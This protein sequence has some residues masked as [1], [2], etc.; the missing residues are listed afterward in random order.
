MKAVCVVGA[1][2]T[3]KTSVVERLVSALDERGR[4]ATVKPMHGDVRVDEEGKDTYRH[5]EAGA[6]RVV[7]VT[8]ERRFDLSDVDDKTVSVAGT[9]DDLADAGYDYS[10]VEGFEESSLPKIATGDTEAPSVV[11]RD[12]TDAT[13]DEL[14]DA[15]ESA[16][17]HETL[18]SLVRRA[19]D[20]DDSPRAGAVATFTGR[21]REENLDDARTTRLEYEKYEAVA[22]ERMEAIRDDIEAREGVYEVEM[23]H[24][25]GVVRAEEDAVHV[26]VLAGHRAEAFRAVE[27]AIDRLKDEVPIFKKEVTEDGEFWVHDRP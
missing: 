17:E 3:G 5:R 14:V 10:V 6:E 11:L 16:D 18:G 27:D 26:V 22:D 4:V 1:S 13:T 25:T 19:E 9:L 20:S 24:E 23:Y 15:V 21:V 7:G 12:A 8:P 2:D